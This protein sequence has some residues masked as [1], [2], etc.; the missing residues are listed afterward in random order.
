MAGLPPAQGPSPY[1]S[2]D[3][4]LIYC[5]TRLRQ[6]DSGVQDKFAKQVKDNDTSKA[7]TEAQNDLKNVVAP[8]WDNSNHAGCSTLGW[9]Q[10]AI[11][12]AGGP[13]TPVGS[14]LKKL[15]ISI[16]GKMGGDA[17]ANVFKEQTSD[18]FRAFFDPAIGGLSDADTIKKFG[19][20]PAA[21]S[22]DDVTGYASTLDSISKDIA[23]GSELDMIDLQSMMS[24]RQ[25][26]IQLT[27][28]LLQIMSDSTNKI[29]ANMHG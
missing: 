29:V 28:N 20:T 11:N 13:D 2:P 12:A 26:A 16:A 27:T 3:A 19:G 5:Q 14:E 10:N 18:N 24:Q 6:I 9:I 7:I 4:I 21:V 17:F 15:Q 1:I 8:G 22:R 25:T 23:A